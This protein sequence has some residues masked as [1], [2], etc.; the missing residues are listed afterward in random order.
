MLIVVMLFL[1]NVC[2]CVSWR[3]EDSSP[4]SALCPAQRGAKP[5]LTAL[6]GGGG[7]ATIELSGAPRPRSGAR[8]RKG[9]EGPV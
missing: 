7:R 1:S 3:V 8:A 9:I 4:S 5:G 2:V 6:A